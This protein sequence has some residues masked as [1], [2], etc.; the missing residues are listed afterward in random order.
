M[1]LSGEKPDISKP[2]KPLRSSKVSGL[3]QTRNI[4]V[5]MRLFNRFVLKIQSR[6]SPK[7]QTSALASS[8][9]IWPALANSDSRGWGTASPVVK[10]YLLDIIGGREMCNLALVGVGNLGAALLH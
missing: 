9:K 10:S 6:S 8:E 5:V 7:E 4:R 3:I 2:K 1:I